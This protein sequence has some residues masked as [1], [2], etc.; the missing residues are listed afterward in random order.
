MWKQNADAHRQVSK[1]LQLDFRISKHLLSFY[2][3]HR[4]PHLLWNG[5][6]LHFMLDLLQELSQC[7][8]HPV[9]QLSH[10]FV[11]L[12]QSLVHQPNFHAAV[13]FPYQKTSTHK[14]SY[15]QKLLKAPPFGLSCFMPANRKGS[16][17]LLALHARSSLFS[18]SGDFKRPFPSSL[19]EKKNNFQEGAQLLNIV[20]EMEKKRFFAFK[21]SLPWVKIIDELKKNNQLRSSSPKNNQEIFSLYSP[22]SHIRVEPLIKRQLKAEAHT[23]W[24]PIGPLVKGVCQCN[25]RG[26]VLLYLLICY[27]RTRTIKPQRSMYLT[28]FHSI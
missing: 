23:K 21:Q 5:R 7:L 11:S 12:Y 19:K 20:E 17:F 22:W 28:V 8:N 4:F 27:L 3:L 13:S 14:K 15:H 24:S 26:N 1:S 6:V 9:S 16:V 2:S 18:R 10:S 25:Y